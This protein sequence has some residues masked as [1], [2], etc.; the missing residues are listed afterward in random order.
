MKILSTKRINEIKRI[1]EADVKKYFKYEIESGRVHWG[2]QQIDEPKIK[3]VENIYI[4]G[5]ESIFFE[6]IKQDKKHKILFTEETKII[7]I[8]LSYNQNNNVGF[9]VSA[10]LE[11]L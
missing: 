5:Y 3:K 7:R 6:L 9:R 10:T 1:F 4:S 11:F 2:Y 8:L